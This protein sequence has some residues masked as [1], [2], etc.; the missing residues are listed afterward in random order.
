MSGF[1]FISDALISATL[2]GIVLASVWVLQ[3]MSH[4]RVGV[5]LIALAALV[6]TLVVG[7]YLAGAIITVMLIT[8]RT[9]GCCT[10]RSLSAPVASR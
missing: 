7:E 3:A 6:G 9:L 1:A 4:R 2:I 5:D 8:G 10:S